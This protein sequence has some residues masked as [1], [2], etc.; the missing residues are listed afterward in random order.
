[1]QNTLPQLV[2][3]EDRL[4]RA[5]GAAEFKIAEIKNQQVR[6]LKQII[7]RANASKSNLDSLL[8]TTKKEKSELFGSADE[9]SK[10]VI[11]VSASQ[12]KI[13][14]IAALAEKLANGHARQG[15][16]ESLVRNARAKSDEIETLLAAITTSKND[17]E[18]AVENAKGSSARAEAELNGLNRSN[19]KADEI[20]NNATQAGLAGAY[21]IEREHLKTQQNW[22]GYVFYGTIISIIIYAAVFLIPIARDLLVPNGATGI[23]SAENAGLLLVRLLIL[24]PAIWALI[25]TNRR[26]SNLESLQMDYAA[27]AAT[28]L[29]YSGYRDEM[30]DDADLNKRLKDGL[31][32]RFLEHPSRLLKNGAKDDVFEHLRAWGDNKKQAATNDKDSSTSTQSSDDE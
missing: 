20:L 6:S 4:N 2:D 29:A 10:A 11:S 26:Y 24:T 28:A 19:K 1:V 17:A 12:K 25:F 9:V 30:G 15:S 22:F 18:I 23:A 14:D 32:I 13:F 7:D 27:K 3:V 31:L 5:V 16:L 21:K 8:E